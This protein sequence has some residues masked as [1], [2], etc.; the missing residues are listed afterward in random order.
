M[1]G[2]GGHLRAMRL[3]PFPAADEPS[4]RQHLSGRPPRRR[5]RLLKPAC[6]VRDPCLIDQQPGRPHP[7]ILSHCGMLL[8]FFQTFLGC[9]HSAAVGADLAGYLVG[10]GL[11]ELIPGG[12]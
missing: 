6:L 10:V 4:R 12:E 7:Q 1:L 11:D 2:D 8:G 5:Q 3:L 9:L